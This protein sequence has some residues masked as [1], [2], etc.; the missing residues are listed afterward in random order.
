LDSGRDPKSACAIQRG[1]L[2]FRAE[3][4]IREGNRQLEDEV[5]PIPYEPMVRSDMDGDIEITGRSARVACEAP[6]GNPKLDA[7]RDAF[8][9]LDR[10][11]PLLFDP[12]LT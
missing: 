1:H 4:G 6:A 11:R 12:T 9:D 10:D 2:D 5:V 3:R 8:R 7:I